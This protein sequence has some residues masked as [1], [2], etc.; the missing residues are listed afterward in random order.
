MWGLP[1]RRVTGPLVR[2]Y[3][4]F[5]PLP[6]AWRYVFCGTFRPLRAL[7]LRGTSPCGV[8]TFLSLIGSDRPSASPTTKDTFLRSYAVQQILQ[9]GGENRVE[10][11]CFTCPGMSESEVRCVKKIPT[12]VSVLFHKCFMLPLAIH[13]VADNGMTD[14]AKVNADLMRSASLDSHLK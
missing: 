9:L 4:T 1:S 7:E 14:R 13:V 6:V 8:R 12:E 2:S 10:L 3:R 5:S 11:Q